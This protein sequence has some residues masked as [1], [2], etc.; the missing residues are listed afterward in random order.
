MPYRLPAGN[1][2]FPDPERE[3]LARAID[4][5]L[6]KGGD[7]ALFATLTFKHYVSPYRAEKQLRRWLARAQQSLKD[8]G[9]YSLKSFCATEWQQ[10]AVIHYHVLLIG[11]GLG[12]LSRKRLESRWESM[13]GGYARCYDADR[14]AAPYLAKYTS[15][16]LG[17]DMKWGGDWRGLRFPTSVSRTQVGAPTGTG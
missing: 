3:V 17:G 10:R 12:S 16:A 6:K 13:G 14:K 5:T 8:S 1:R 7:S 15:K 4:W 11:H 9:G 2:F